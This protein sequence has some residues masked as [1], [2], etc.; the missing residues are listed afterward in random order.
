MP[1]YFQGI[2]SKAQAKAWLDIILAESRLFL[3]KNKKEKVLG[4]VFISHRQ[5]Q[6]NYQDKHLGYLL[7]EEQLGKG[8]ASEL[9]HAFIKQAE[10]WYKLIGGVDKHNFAS[11][12]VLLKPGFTKRCNSSQSVDFY[13]LSLSKS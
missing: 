2:E 7:A 5:G 1:P 12:K 4:C 11:A 10:S 3:V 13:E 8:L 6:G 9:F